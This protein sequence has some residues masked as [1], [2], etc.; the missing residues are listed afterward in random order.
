[1]QFFLKIRIC[2]FCKVACCKEITQD[3]EKDPVLFLEILIVFPIFPCFNMA[4]N[5][6]INYVCDFP[7]V[8]DTDKMCT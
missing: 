2:C 1:M 7:P 4:R 6:A 3:L 5:S 8:S